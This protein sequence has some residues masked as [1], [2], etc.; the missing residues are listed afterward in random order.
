MPLT[1]PDDVLRRVGLTEEEARVEFACRL[2]ESGRIGL[3]AARALAGL[4][5]AAMEDA[6]LDRGIPIY[7]LTVEDVRRDVETLRRAGV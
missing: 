1:I 2:F 4:T 7:H 3:H 5:R 6:L